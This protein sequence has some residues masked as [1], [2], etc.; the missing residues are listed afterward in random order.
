[1]NILYT[2]IIY[3]LVQI[4]E[5]IYVLV[6]VIFRN[7][8]VAVIGVSAA[9]TLLCL[10]LYIVA[11]KWQ[12]VE[13]DTQRKLKPYTDRIKT[14]FKG[15]E[16]YMVLSTYYRQ[17][18][19]H[20]LMALRSSFGLLIQIPFFIAAYSFLSKN[21]SLQGV[22]F[23]FIRDMGMPDKL[24]SI[25]GF[26]VN[27]LPILMTLINCIA[28]AVYTK[29]FPVK[30]KVQIYG[31]AAIFLILLYNSPA[32][33]V[34]Y[35]T[36]NNI[37]S[38]I[39][40][41]FYKLKNPLKVF[42]IFI[43]I[44]SILCCFY[45]LTL[46]NKKIAVVMIGL[47]FV[48]LVLPFIIAGIRRLLN[49]ILSGLVSDS[50]NRFA[51]FL[52]S[53]LI[54]WLLTGFVIP[55]FLVVSSPVEYSYIDSYTT[56]MYFLG[57]SLQQAAGFFLFWP[58]CIYFLFPKKIKTI[59]SISS[60]LFATGALINSFLFSGDYGTIL[61]QLVFTE[62]PVFI[63]TI[64]QFL[65]NTAALLI[66][67]VLIFFL[68]KFP[69]QKVLKPV[70]LMLFSSLVIISIVH[71]VQIQKAFNNI[72]IASKE[73][74]KDEI[75]PIFHFSKDNPN[76]V[77]FMLDRAISLF[78]PAIFEESP[79]LTAA[80]S[81]FVYYPNT[82]SFS[83][84]TIQGAPPLYGGYEYTPFEMN[85]RRDITMAEKHNESL[86]LQSIIFSEN[87]YNAAVIDPPYPNYDIPP[88]FGMFDPYPEITPITAKGVYSDLWFHENNMDPIPIKSTLIKRNFIFF[89][90]FKSVPMLF[91]V[92]VQ[93]A[94]WWNVNIDIEDKMD[95]IN[96]YSVLDYLPE[97][98]SVDNEKPFFAIID[99]EMTHES[100]FLQ[101]P[102][103]VPVDTVTDFGTSEYAHNSTYHTNIAA[104][105]RVAEWLDYLKLEGVYDNTRIIIVADHGAATL[106]S[107]I[108]EGN[109]LGKRKEY[110]NPLLLVKDFNSQ[111]SFRTDYA[112]M[113]N[114]DVPALA[115]EGLIDNP[116]NPFTKKEIRTLTID[117]K[118]AASIISFSN[119]KG[120]R[121]TL[122]NGFKITDNEWYTVKN[123][124]FKES[125]WSKLKK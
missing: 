104:L 72:D 20:P 49:G 57:N 110:F 78:L 65:G 112:Y 90:I 124:I 101:A 109:N 95:L 46:K 125:N 118:N 66:S 103:Y 9:V 87:G 27:V 58:L 53:F 71:T 30:E 92:L 122:N 41:I 69:Q 38:L 26:A 81:G 96:Y 7:P 10:P 74:Q 14:T 18:H 107:K 93:Y 17:N 70:L 83:R 47:T 33:L 119:G 105:K 77:V 51:L 24:I 60:V 120:V 5:I 21:E 59:F 34:L 67:A 50:K 99:N 113:T 91:R 15:D 111:E 82:I 106:E 1:M 52:M 6:N 89:G 37:F 108:F 63:P 97:L 29:G 36:M 114:A 8:G 44:V 42:Y 2:L 16:Q 4:I 3:P 86:M 61:P 64:M 22:S 11:E 68:V 39:K 28:G 19:Y 54:I 56:P 55:S 117:E 12:Q 98:T 40:N 23:L 102:D 31:M 85:K 79:D 116:I 94:D 73:P 62:H 25:G 32:G 84:W 76:V 48:I 43:S 88:V 123:N 35:W 75:E 100:N 45:T 80:Y 13:R 121:E 115:M